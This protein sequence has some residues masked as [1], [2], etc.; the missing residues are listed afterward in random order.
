MSQIL[1]KSPITYSFHHYNKCSVAIIAHSKCNSPSPLLKDTLR[2]EPV[3]DRHIHKPQYIW[4]FNHPRGFFCRENCDGCA[5][6]VNQPVAWRTLYFQFPL[7]GCHHKVALWAFA[8]L[9]FICSC[10]ATVSCSQ[11]IP[12]HGIL[13][14]GRRQQIIII[15]NGHKLNRVWILMKNKAFLKGEYWLYWSYSTYKQLPLI[16]STMRNIC[17]QGQ[18]WW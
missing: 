12:G 2:Y 13:S 16:P 7:Y 1:L 4:N 5:W 10:C 3:S 15:V 18:W 11:L 9:H 6:Q 14:D 8:F 17:L